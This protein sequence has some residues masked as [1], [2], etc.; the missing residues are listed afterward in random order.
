MPRNQFS[1]IGP[2]ILGAVGQGL[3]VRQAFQNEQNKNLLRE[4]QQSQL[5]TRQRAVGVPSV[6]PENESQEDS[7]LRMFA[8][9][10]ELAT[11]LLK[12]LGINSQQQK[13]E[14]ADFALDVRNTKDPEK[15][16][17]KIK[18]RIESL[19]KGGRD[20][21][22]T[23]DLLGQNPETLDGAL[24]NLGAAAL[25][26]LQRVKSKQAVLDSSGADEVQSSSM[27]PGGVVQ[28]VR[29]SGAVET[30]SPEQASAQ[31]IRN[32]ED[33]GVNLQ[34]KRAQGR[35]LGKD[36][37]KAASTASKEVT[38]LRRNNLLLKK[39]IGEVKA[40]ADTGPLSSKLPSFRAAS[41][42][43][44]QL[45]NKLGLDVVGSV[46]F[47]ALS[48]GELTLA[49]STALPNALQGPELIKWT[50]DKISAQ[51]KL[52]T[53]LEDQAIFLSEPGNTSA[54]WIQLQRRQS[55]QKAPQSSTQ[56]AVQSQSKTSLPPGVTEEDVTETMRIHGVTR[57]QVLERISQ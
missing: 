2:D 28:I 10:P 27:M 25:T 46:T 15:K 16:I 7:K 29:K 26:E 5:S 54:K 53:Y 39:V 22:S 45:R 49:L 44:N 56:S 12:G 55:A 38:S 42:R 20:A 32:A 19:I 57:Q 51:E 30:I 37:A 13:Q 31:I 3:S 14:A 43:L 52:A 11:K 8:D 40:G 1:P 17:V 35:T 6:T 33:R 24:E 23:M 9:N 41:V 34:Q 18:R 50:E 47:G 4:Q 21:T 36:A 48:E